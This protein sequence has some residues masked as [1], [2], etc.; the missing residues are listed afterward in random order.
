MPTNAAKHTPVIVGVA[1]NEQ[2]ITNWET[3]KEPLELMYEALQAAAVDCSNP[4]I[5]E[6]ATAVRVVR[7][8]WPYTIP[9]PFCANASICPGLKRPLASLAATLCRR[10]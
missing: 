9:R 4:K 6:A 5:I 1:Q 7:G 2:R 10:W 3:H 8:R